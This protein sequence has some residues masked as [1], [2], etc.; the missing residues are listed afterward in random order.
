MPEIGKGR[1]TPGTGQVGYN[2]TS[3]TVQPTAASSGFTLPEGEGGRE[4]LMEL[5]TRVISAE[6]KLTRLTQDVHSFAGALTGFESLIT[7]EDG[8]NTSVAQVLATYETLNTQVSSLNASLST[9]GD[10]VTALEE[11]PIEEGQGLGEPIDLTAVNAALNTLDARLDVL[12][13]LVETA[14]EQ[15]TDLVTQLANAVADLNTKASQAGVDAIAASVLTK[16]NKT[17]KINTGGLI[18]GGKAIDSDVNLVVQKATAAE[19]DA[20]IIDHKA[21]T[22]A[23]LMNVLSSIRNIEEPI[24]IGTTNLIN[25]RLWLPGTGGSRGKFTEIVTAG[26]ATNAIK[27]DMGPLGTIEPVWSA[28]TLPAAVSAINDINGGFEYC[29]TCHEDDFDPK[30]SFRF[31]VFVKQDSLSGI[32]NFNCENTVTHLNGQ[33]VSTPSFLNGGFNLPE[34]NKWYLLVGMVHGHTFT[35]TDTTSGIY[36]L[37]TGSKVVDGLSFKSKAGVE[38]QTLRIFRQNAAVNAS[39]LQFARPRIDIITGEEPTIRALFGTAND[40]DKANVTTEIIGAG[41]AQGGGDLSQDRTITVPKATDQ[42]IKDGLTDASAITPKGLKTNLIHI[43]PKATDLDVHQLNSETTV[44]TPKSLRSLPKASPADVEARTSNDLFLTPASLAGVDLG[45][46]GGGGGGGEAPIAA[47]PGEV[48]AMSNNTKMVTPLALTGL[49]KASPAQVGAKVSNTVFVTPASLQGLTLPDTMFAT[50]QD[51]DDG[52]STTKIVTPFAMANVPKGM[53]T[54]EDMLGGG[55][56]PLMSMNPF[57]ARGPLGAGDIP[58]DQLAV[59]PTTFLA[60]AAPAEAVNEGSSTALYITPAALAA[61]DIATSI[62]NFNNSNDRNGAPIAAPVVASDGT[63]VDHV[64]NTDGSASVTFEWSWDGDEASIDGFI[65]L[66]H[67]SGTNTAYPFDGSSD[68]FSVVIPA[69]KRAIL[70]PGVAA[71]RY[72]SF[73]VK[74]YRIVD[75]DI[76][77]DGFIYS[78]VAKSTHVSELPYQPSANVAFAGDVIGTIDGV[79]VADITD[80]VTNFNDA[81]DRNGDP[82]PV[83]VLSGSGSCVDHTK[84]NDG[85]VNISFEWA[86]PDAA[87]NATQAEEASIDGFMVSYRIHPT[88]TAEYLFTN[89]SEEF[90][91]Y[92]PADKR[93]LILPGVPA[94]QNFS[95]GVMAYRAVDLDINPTGFIKTALVTPNRAGEKPYKPEANIAFFGNIQGTVNNVSVAEI[96][97]GIANFNARNDRLNTAIPAPTIATNGTAIDHILNND[98]S[99]DIS[100]EWGWSGDNADID[101]FYVTFHAAPA[102]ATPP[103]MHPFN[104]PSVEVVIPVP[105]DRRAIFLTGVAA[106]KWYSFAVRAYR[107]V[108]SDINA[109]GFIYSPQVVPTLAAEAPYRPT[110]NLAFIGELTGTIDGETLPYVADAARNF[111]ARNDRNGTAVT[112]PTVEQDGTAIDHVINTDGSA[113]ISFEWG[114]AGDEDDIDGFILYR[115]VST[116]AT[117]NNFTTPASEMVVYLPA[118]KRSVIIPGIPADRYYSFGIRSYRIVDNDVSTAAGSPF[119]GMIVSA[120]VLP[121]ADVNEHPYRPAS[122]VAFNGKITGT[123]GNTS[124]S[125]VEAAVANFDGRNDRIS[126]PVI[127]PTI[128]SDGT[129][130]DHVI[131]T[132]GSATISFEWA[133]AGDEAEIDGF[134]FYHHIGTS[135]TEH[136]FTTPTSESAVLVPANKRAIIL[137]GQPA[138]KYHSFGIRAYRV[139]DPDIAAGGIIQTT[140]VTPSAVGEKPY[141]PATEVAFAGDISGTI[142]GVSV[143]TVTDAVQN[144]NDRN[145]RLATAISAPTIAADGS[146][147]D[148][149]NNPDG[150]VTITFEWDWSGDEDTIDGFMV[151]QHVGTTNSA[152]T[153][154]GGNDE[155]IIYLPANKRGA[156]FVGVPATRYYSF[157]VR[158]YR[159][160]DADVNSTGFVYSTLAT[161]GLAAEYPYRPSSGTVIGG[162]NDGT[163]GAPV[164]DIV[165][166][167]QQAEDAYNLATAINTEFA[168]FSDDG[169][170]TYLERLSIARSITEATAERTA[171]R[172]SGTAFG[173]TT[174]MTTEQTAWDAMIG[175]LTAMTPPYNNTADT[176]SST[177]DRADYNSKVATWKTALQGL[178]NK[179]ATLASQQAEWD[180]VTGANRPADGAT[181]NDYRGEWAGS[182]A[183]ITGDLVTYEGSAFTVIAPHTS[184]GGTPPPNANIALLSQG[185]NAK[186]VSL[187]YT[188]QFIRFGTDGAAKPASQTLSFTATLK[189]TI[190]TTATFTAQRFNA[191]N[192]S[193][194]TVTMGGTGNT[195]TLTETQF[196]NASYVKVT[197]SAPTDGFSDLVTVIRVQDGEAALGGFLTNESM[198]LSADAGGTVASFSS[199]VGTFKVFYGSTDVTA[200]C[201]FS[202][203]AQSGCSVTI[204]SSTGA[205]AV[206]DMTADNATA[207]FEAVFGGLTVQKGLSLA[208]SKAGDVGVTGY[209][210][211][212]SHV[213]AADQSGTVASFIGSGGVFKVIYGLTDVTGTST[214]YSVVS[215]T[216]VDI[217]IN[218]TTGVYSIDSMSADEGQAVLRC[219]FSGSTPS[220]TIDKVYS[221]TK[222]RA[223][224]TGA[225]GNSAK[226]MSAVADRSFVIYDSTNAISPP[227]QTTTFSVSKQ[228]TSATVNWTIKD[229]KGNTITPVSTY[230]SSAT[231]DVVT[232]TATQF[233]T[234]IG[235]NTADALTVTATIEDG[236]TITDAITLNKL[237]QGTN[238]VLGYLTNEA[239]TLAASGTGTVADFSPAAGTFKVYFGTTDITTGV[240]T[241]YAVTAQTNCT[242][243]INSSTGVYS[244]TAMSADQASL[245]MT[246]TASS[247]YGNVVTTRV[248]T[249]SKS[250]AGAAGTAGTNGINAKLLMVNSDRQTVAFDGAGTIVAGQTV[251]LRT[252]KQNTTSPIAWTISSLGGAPVTNTSTY[253]TG[254]STRT[255]LVAY[256]EKLGAAASANWWADLNV[257]VTADAI[258]APDNLSTADLIIPTTT[259]GL[260]R[261]QRSGYGTGVIGDV[262]TASVY[263]KAGGLEYLGMLFPCVNSN[264]TWFNLTTGT[265]SVT[266]AGWTAAIADVGNGWFRCSVTGTTTVTTANNN[267]FFVSSTPSST[268]FAGNGTSGIYMWGAQFAVEPTVGPYIKTDGA[269]VTAVLGESV[270]LTGSA[271][272]TVRSTSEGVTV[273]ATL[274]D[275]APISDSISISK[276]QAGANSVTGYLTNEGHLVAT[277]SAGANPDF[278][279]AGGTFKVY[280]GTTDITTGQGTTYSASA[281]GCTGS[282]N[283]T[284]GVYSITAMSADNATL[285]LTANTSA[286]FGTITL[287]KVFS[288]T[289][290]KAG[291]AGV[292]AKVVTLTSDRQAILVDALGALTPAGTAQSIQFIANKRNTTATTNWFVTKLDGSATA[293]VPANNYFSTTAGGGTGT[294][295]G[296]IVYMTPA[297]F[298]AARGATGGVIVR[299]E[300]VDGTAMSDSVSVLRLQAGQAAVNGVLTNED[301]TLPALNDG[302]VSDYS[303]ATGTFKVFYGTTDISTGQG[304]T[305]SVASQSNVTGSINAT[306]GVYTV[307]SM[308]ADTGSLTLWANTTSTYGSALVTKTFTLSKAKTGPQGVQGAGA[309]TLNITADRYTITYDNNNLS[310]AT[311]TT[312]FTAAKVNTTQTVTWT[313]TTVDGTA[314]TPVTTYLSAATGDTV[315]MTATQFHNARGA[316]RGVVVKGTIVDG[317]TI[318]DTNSLIMVANGSTVVDGYLTNES[319]VF[320]AD[321]AGTVTNWS[322]S[323]GSFKVFYGA[324]DVTGSSTT[325]ALV[326]ATPGTTATIG[327]ATGDYSVTA[328]SADSATVRFSA[329]TS[330]ANG[331]VTVYK[332]L[333]LAKSK[334][335][336]TGNAGASAKN[337]RISTDRQSILVDAFGN[338]TPSGTAQSVKFT[339]NTQ[340]TTGTPAWT[341]TK[342][343]G[344]SAGPGGGFSTTAAGGTTTTSGATVYMTPTQFDAARGATNGVIVTST[345][346]GVSDTFTVLRLQAGGTN[347][348]G[349]LSNE[350]QVIGTDSAGNNGDFGPATGTFKVYYG[351]TDISVGM[352]TVYSATTQTNCTGS[353]NATTGV[354]SVTAMSADTASLTLT[355]TTSSTYGSVVVTKTFALAKS[356]TGAVGPAAKTIVVTS[357][358]QTISYDTSNALSPSLQTT[359]FTAYKQNTSAVVG[360]T[361]QDT[362]GNALS[363]SL[364]SATTGDTTTLTAAN[365]QTAIAT[366]NANGVLVIGTITDGTTIADKV[367]LLK[368]RDGAVG[369]PGNPGAPGAPGAPG[370]AA[371][372]GY[373]TNEA[374]ILQTDIN[375]N[376]GDLTQAGGTFKVFDGTTDVTTSAA[377]SVVSTTAGLTVNIGASTGVY[378]V[379]AMTSDS[380]SAV[381]RAVYGGV[382]IDKVYGIAKAKQGAAGSAGANAKMLRV[383]CDRQTITYDGAGALSPASQPITFTTIRQNTSATPTWSVTDIN[384]VAQSGTLLSATSGTSITMTAANFNTARNGTNGIIVYGSVSDGGTFTDQMTVVKI[385]AGADGP[386]GPA[387]PAISIAPSATDF[388]YEDGALVPASQTITLTAN[389]SGVSGTVNWST[390]PNIKTGTGTTF[391]VNQTEFNG[392]SNREVIV[393]ATVGGVS[394]TVALKRSDKLSPGYL[395]NID[396]TMNDTNA[397]KADLADMDDGGKIT[398]KEKKVLKRIIRAIDKEYPLL[399]TKAQTLGITTELSTYQN[400]YSAL[401][402]YLNTTT[403]LTN[404]SVTT[405]INAVTFD[406]KFDDYYDAQA[407]LIAAMHAKASTMADWNGPISNRPGYLTDGRLGNAVDANGDLIRN[408]PLGI[409]NGSNIFRRT[410]GGLFTG[411]VNATYGA[412][413]NTNVANRTMDYLLD[414]ATYGRLRNTQLSG[415]NHK[416][417][418]AGSGTRVGDQRNLPS[419]TAMNLSYK[420]NG[421]LTYASNST[422]SITISTTAATVYIGS[423]S[424]SYNAMSVNVS[425]TAGSTWTYFL[426][427][428]DANYAGGSKTLVATLTGN[429]IYTDDSRVYVGTVTVSFPA[430][431]GGSTGGTGGGGGGGGC[432]EADSWVLTSMGYKRARDVLAGDY[433]LVLTD[434]G[435]KSGIPTGGVQWQMCTSNKV[436][437][438]PSF[439]IVSESGAEVIC[440][441]STPITLKDGTAIVPW[442]VNGTELPVWVNNELRWEKCYSTPVGSADV[443]YISCGMKIYA[444]G[445]EQGSLI[446]THNP[447][448]NVAKP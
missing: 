242:G 191:S 417:T 237:R 119:P 286:A 189:N 145:D 308:T 375:G 320:A 17:T 377:F 186:S 252:V 420:W 87:N 431:T 234:A 4:F 203:A 263:A 147:V 222:S 144:F 207:T 9:L 409:L 265:V 214:A 25:S 282:I 223:G 11:L 20:G 192:A 16:A 95:F 307:T 253:L 67:V 334:Q 162:G 221:I 321:N 318:T 112:A 108:D 228:N 339:A 355:A 389:L 314:V 116:T 337:L 325:Y 136:T 335:G 381:L 368:V 74:A 135:N 166:A 266:G 349:V 229:N 22:P 251:T 125:T 65:V 278:T 114:Y 239:Q 79:P 41:L 175:V 392:A 212:E 406:Q 287:T 165:A 340:N 407:G 35:G 103:A 19:V 117:A 39:K 426:Y 190:D 91:M 48:T 210:S 231:G 204:N 160:V 322:A 185:S 73:A 258:T 115:D 46:G 88:D 386:T 301:Q 206:T 28:T 205:Y 220:V 10:R 182:T 236:A 316:T 163:G 53:A 43:L 412:D 366:N 58:L 360:W 365:F 441:D 85:S 84:N 276:I 107:I 81:N 170:I 174:E 47:T 284:T 198:A 105:A 247:A 98:S 5:R 164:E 31:S 100:F 36:D 172:T 359:T 50:Q 285:T 152:H 374:H 434:T 62:T 230:L 21:V 243:T 8:E 195:R 211:N 202:V 224:A 427:L 416:L 440:S 56:E 37:A 77:D 289:K 390:S 101:G 256:S 169:V 357:D 388:K 401:N 143:A 69:D 151:Y 292:T 59:S 272:N 154:T 156:N 78:P 188:S 259:S 255:N 76:D 367:S 158:A 137:G 209:L 171:L 428:D 443:A 227:T 418:V 432:V 51:V 199:A 356:K 447:Y 364:L 27:L 372:V 23:S 300:V 249:L 173:V 414:G 303:A 433:I 311:Q 180:N 358:R 194:G 371:K 238:S 55:G 293:L 250:R 382:T 92:V 97:D 178:A 80:V 323:S 70:Q 155:A 280:S 29:I 232:M 332:T 393:T 15:I 26:T 157:A 319:V 246:A 196:G 352:G 64:I 445:T 86:W 437:P 415:G 350:A 49:P 129:A 421:S 399:N 402:T 12:E 435:P 32:L 269:S 376:G 133:W 177:V 208:K 54:P 123:V 179:I 42:E 82:I 361:I 94:D 305:Y 38:Q 110:E 102:N 354:Y 373:L 213:V 403:T 66:F 268:N 394:S 83:P 297:Q 275:P 124:V 405:T 345:V 274:A 439:K 260:H 216:G 217:S 312:T 120:I 400:A 139:V 378:T 424:I 328:M 395:S 267:G 329:T 131:N 13:P 324:T 262:V 99:C 310:P 219:V 430:T 341:L 150:T 444:A 184:A 118:N 201:T 215:E 132:D 294:S 218:A 60:M 90:V 244:V 93:S 225:A 14:N 330:A 290:S 348:S 111:N 442:K 248:F 404:Y 283:A 193:L 200:S 1:I 391:T 257:N 398:K 187:S 313:V 233:D 159:I 408:I 295:T 379:T 353:I 126:T 140:I 273:I 30:H 291:T 315:T 240:G 397:A 72:Y 264:Y 333:T 109:S 226:V 6:D 299:C 71:D 128:L 167:V 235:L 181:R 113:S 298:D 385:Q 75:V 343:D 346:D 342:L 130:V 344:T 309:K 52:I 281:T 122:E 296:D 423:A 141:Q 61:S 153:F 168:D 127:L 89:P 45:T 3:K 384:G 176:N 413:L 422:T 302:T 241:V 142:N 317:T 7:T 149:L 419:I 146:A 331:G 106:D 380:A 183:Y 271:F 438:Q 387:G 304:T 370:V 279:G 446:F 383:L 18:T 33:P 161:P 410:G 448:E 411:D 44:V 306:T 261:I 254:S 134:I 96:T 396:N 336:A 245:T 68:E 104:N 40:L 369:S 326:S 197:A 34:T 363:N 338:L 288:V 362:S 351:S 436:I 63:A 270:T 425:G 429:D 277:D 24:G 121:T 57:S 138:D 2:K 327:A 148:H 347:V